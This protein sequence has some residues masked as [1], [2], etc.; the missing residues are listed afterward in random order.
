MSSPRSD[1]T[2]RKNYERYI[3][4][5]K[6]ADCASPGRQPL[7][8]RKTAARFWKGVWPLPGAVVMRFP[9]KN[10]VRRW[11]ARSRL[12]CRC[13]H[14]SRCSRNQSGDDRRS[15]LKSMSAMVETHRLAIACPQSPGGRRAFSPSQ[16][17]TKRARTRLPSPMR[18]R[19]V[20]SRQTAWVFL[21]HF[22]KFDLDQ[23]LVIGDT[24]CASTRWGRTSMRRHPRHNCR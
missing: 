11:I 20:P 2:I 17:A 24:S 14:P 12:P 6:T 1:G 8:R 15:G 4:A 21:E 10:H 3:A 18:V 13:R 22:E 9:S 7:P 16:S 19:L 23:H 5:F